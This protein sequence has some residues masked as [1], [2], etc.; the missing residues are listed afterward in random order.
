MH[1]MEAPQERDL[2]IGAVRPVLHEIGDQQDAEQLGKER[3]STH[4]FLQRR[5]DQ[6]A[7]QAMDGEVHDHQRQSDQQVVDDEMREVDLPARPEIGCSQCSGNIF[8]I[9]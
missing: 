9:R 1:G 6:P 2:V 4:P 8:S 3:Q 7:E 5:T